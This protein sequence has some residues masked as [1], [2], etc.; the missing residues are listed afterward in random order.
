MEGRKSAR[1]HQRRSSPQLVLNTRRLVHAGSEEVLPDGSGGGGGERNGNTLGVDC[2]RLA[3]TQTTTVCRLGSQQQ[4]QQQQ[5]VQAKRS[6]L[7]RLFDWLLSTDQRDLLCF[8]YT[9]RLYGLGESTTERDTYITNRLLTR[10]LCRNCRMERTVEA[11]QSGAHR[12]YLW[13]AFCVAPAAMFRPY[14]LWNAG[15]RRWQIGNSRHCQSHLF[16][17]AAQ[18][19]AYQQFADEDKSASRTSFP[20]QLP[21]V[22]GEGINLIRMTLLILGNPILNRIRCQIL[23]I[24]VSL[25]EDCSQD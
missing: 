2:Q 7:V 3:M 16:E 24:N 17:V 15:K 9:E 13:T 21:H 19:L 14:T 18:I 10:S 23:R 8:N 4:Q 25:L 5:R 12:I 11:S 1:W 20:F 22:T 6:R